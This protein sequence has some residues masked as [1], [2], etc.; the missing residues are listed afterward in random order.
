MEVN[1]RGVKNLV[2]EHWNGN[3]QFCTI[4]HLCFNRVS[5]D[6]PDEIDTF[7]FKTSH[8]KFPTDLVLKLQ[9]YQEVVADIW[10]AR[11]QSIPCCSRVGKFSAEVVYEKLNTGYLQ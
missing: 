10:G 7:L 6:S 9:V 5:S 3:A 4:C 8:S 11:G 1:V 2:T